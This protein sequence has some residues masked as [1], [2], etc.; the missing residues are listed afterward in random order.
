M[1]S[2]YN[3]T[4]FLTKGAIESVA[5]VILSIPD[6]NQKLHPIAIFYGINDR[7]VL[8]Y[9]YDFTVKEQIN[10]FTIVLKKEA[11]TEEVLTSLGI[12]SQMIA[13]S[14]NDIRHNNAELNTLLDEISRLPNI[15]NPIKLPSI[16]TN[17]DNQTTKPFDE[18][19]AFF[20]EDELSHLIPK[21]DRT[22]MGIYSIPTH[23]DLSIS[24]ASTAVQ[25]L[26]CIEDFEEKRFQS[27]VEMLN[28]PDVDGLTQKGAEAKKKA[29]EIGKRP[30]DTKRQT[31]FYDE[32]GVN[33]GD[34]LDT[35][36]KYGSLMVNV[37]FANSRYKVR[38]IR[39]IVGPYDIR[40]IR[41]EDER[42][43]EVLMRVEQISRVR[44]TF[45]SAI[46]NIIA[47]E[48]EDQLW[49][50][51]DL[52]SPEQ[53]SQISTEPQSTDATQIAQTKMHTPP[54]KSH[55]STGRRKKTSYS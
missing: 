5:Y 47:Q 48:T 13:Y 45:L 7:E 2:A 29:L 30:L 24:E 14:L 17:L 27:F 33:L 55:R 1:L 35:H 44:D 52:L 54:K 31:E 16:L 20:N 42:I 18:V 4:L 39:E 43:R 26:T 32:Y 12:N 46:E 21:L 6:S 36:R 28:S 11:N 38:H 8:Q 22:R 34:I 50:P 15:D 23:Q 10:N 37:L 19:F 25:I 9:F 3:T 53:V 40:P 51:T 49:I 41:S